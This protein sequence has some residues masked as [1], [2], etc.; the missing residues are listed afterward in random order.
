M[1]AT[2]FSF[3]RIIVAGAIFTLSA[4]CD[5][6]DAGSNGFQPHF[7]GQAPGER[8]AILHQMDGTASA[9]D[10]Q[11]MTLTVKSAEGEKAFKV[12]SK[13]K[14][15]RNAASVAMT[16]VA[17]GQPVRVVVKSVYGQPDEIVSVDIKSK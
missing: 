5:G 11:G 12:T 15:T 16:D 2:P 8:Q 13:T 14:F 3:L 17:V 4:L 6:Q 1:T 10:K 7:D 9:M